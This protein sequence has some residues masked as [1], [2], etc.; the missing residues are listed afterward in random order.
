M[1]KS[2]KWFDSFLIFG[3]LSLCVCPVLSASNNFSKDAPRAKLPPLETPLQ[4]LPLEEHLFYRVSWMGIPV[5]VGQLWVREKASLD[6]RD[7]LHVVAIAET[8]DFLSKIYPVRDEVHSWIDEKTLQSL[9]FEKK[10]SEGR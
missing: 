5:G 3:A 9:Q 10:V 1:K 2:A 7:C 6:G 4:N 8:S